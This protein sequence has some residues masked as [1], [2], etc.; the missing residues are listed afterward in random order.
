[1]SR[2]TKI[3]GFKVGRLPGWFIPALAISGII[4]VFNMK[5][6]R[7]ILGIH[8]EEEDEEKTPEQVAAEPVIGEEGGYWE[9]QGV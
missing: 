1:M 8:G 3:L 6:T 7:E 2:S 9:S 5:S 4:C